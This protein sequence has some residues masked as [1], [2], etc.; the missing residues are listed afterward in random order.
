MFRRFSIQVSLRV[1]TI[2]II[3]F[4]LAY[5]LGDER[6]F[7]NQVILAVALAAVVYNLI[8]YVH[9]TNRDVKRLLDA[10]KQ[11][12]FTASFKQKKLGKNFS[13]MYA[14][15]DQILIAF[16]TVKV[17]KEAQYHFLQLLVEHI[18]LGIIATAENGDITL[19][20]SSAKEIMRLENIRSWPHLSK[21][22]PEF[23]AK[24]DE[25]GGSG[26]RLI[27]LGNVYGAS[28]LTV[29]VSSTKLLDKAV[30]LIT[31]KDIENEI[32]QKELEA[33]HKLIRILTHEIMNSLTPVSSLTETMQ[34][35]LETGDGQQIEAGSLSAETIDDLRFS[36]QTIR[37]RS[38]EMLHFVDDYRKVTKVPE[39]VLENVACKKVVDQIIRLL[40]ADLL[41]DEIE[42]IEDIETF[43]LKI[44]QGLVVQILINLVKN[45][46]HALAGKKNGKIILRSYQDEK[47]RYIS[48]KD[49][50]TGIEE[51]LLKEIFIPFFTTKEA[52]SGIG[53]SLS[54]QIMSLHEG[55]IRV[56]S[57]VGEGTTVTLTFNK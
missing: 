22:R 36:L 52:G 12:D 13:R 53:L 20:N 46:Q 9:Q 10:I 30:R 16:D 7:F 17:E 21:E 28:R 40:S 18:N 51:E 45:S 43:E 35:M 2:L 1:L 38:D 5:I 55:R 4:L 56:D 29:E 24:V 31:F 49:N 41:Q 3:A 44:D 47:G 34:S 33:W 50:G 25:M 6:L 54:K 11:S 23:T 8:W 39:P 57:K 26:S 19:V 27:E 48:V 14:S 42:L 32:E 37:K 15:F